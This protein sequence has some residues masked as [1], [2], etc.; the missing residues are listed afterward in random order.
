MS[1]PRHFAVLRSGSNISSRSATGRAA[2]TSRSSRRR[3]GSASRPSSSGPTRLGEHNVAVVL[4]TRTWQAYNFRDDD[5]DGHGDTWYATRGHLQ[6]QLGRPYLNRGVP[7]HYRQ[8]DVRFLRWLHQTGHAV[9]VLS[10]AELEGT[11]GARLAAAYELVIFP[12]HHEYVTKREYDAVQS[13]RNRGGNLMF[14]SANNFF[15]RIDLRGRTMTRVAKWRD[16]GRPEAALLG[17]QYIGNDMGE[18]RGPWLVQAAAASSWIFD[19]IELRAGQRV[20]RRGHRDRRR[21][22][23]LTARDAHPRRD[24]EPARPR[25]DRAHDVLR[26]VRR[27]EGVRRGRLLARRL[28]PA[29]GG[30]AAAHEPVGGS[31][32]PRQ[33]PRRFERAWRLSRAAVT[34]DPSRAR[35]YH[36]RRMR[37]LALVVL[38]LTFVPAAHAAEL[39]VSP[40]Q[41]SPL[42]RKLRCARICPRPSGSASSSR[43]PP[44]SRSAGSPTPQLRRY[45]TLRWNGRLN[46]SARPGRA[47]PDPPRRSRARARVLSAAHRPDAADDHQV[48]RPQPRPQ[49]VPGRRQAPDD[50]LART[51]T[52]C[53]SRPRSASR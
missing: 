46:G 18:H 23:E 40:R 26:D 53:A 51:A 4:P 24:P 1:A 20:L 16:L 5:G 10:Q 41:F 30:A 37:R 21:R 17:V 2:S 12:G 6:A 19:G 42:E 38:A 36:A 15:W 8:Y 48:R 35:D 14:L 22:P 43:P 28:D 9:D 11:T 33:R 25:D 27:R 7:P 39:T 49:P 31:R 44:A 3:A 13:F 45:L 29:A 50:H 47:V 52:A 32:R 34:F